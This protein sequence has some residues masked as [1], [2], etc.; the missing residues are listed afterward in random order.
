MEILKNETIDS[1]VLNNMR[2]NDLVDQELLEKHFPIKSNTATRILSF[3]VDKKYKDLNLGRLYCN[4]KYDKKIYSTLLTEKYISI[5]IKDSYV[6]CLIEM[7]LS[8]DCEVPVLLEYLTNKE[9]IL[10]SIHSDIKCAKY[11][12]LKQCAGGYDNLIEVKYNNVKPKELSFL[13]KLKDEIDLLAEKCYKI[14][15]SNYYE[16]IRRN[17][18][19][20]KHT[21]LALLIQTK[22]RKKVSEL[23][24]F[25]EKEYEVG[26]IFHNKIFVKTQSL[27]KLEIN[28]EIYKV[29]KIKPIYKLLSFDFE[30]LAIEQF[31]DLMGDNLLIDVNNNIYYFDTKTGAFKQNDLSLHNRHIKNMI[32]KLVFGGKDYADKKDLYEKMYSSLPINL[33]ER[34]EKIT[35]MENHR[36]SG[37]GKLLFA[38]GYYDFKTKTFTKG[39]NNKILFFDAISYNFPERPPDDIMNNL[40]EIITK[41]GFTSEYYESGDYLLKALTMAIYGDYTR[42][43]IYFVTGPTG[44]GK[45]MLTEF[46]KFT[47]GDYIDNSFAAE[48]LKEKSSDGGRDYSRSIYWLKDIAN[49]RIV[50]SNECS[51]ADKSYDL[52]L[53]K[54]LSSDA[55]KLKARNNYGK[56]EEIM[57]MSTMFIYDNSKM[58][59]D[60]N[61]MEGFEQRPEFI[62]YQISHVDED[63]IVKDFHRKKD[64][65]IKNRLNTEIYRNALVHLI[66]DT[67]NNMEYEEKRDNGAIKRPSVIAKN[68]MDVIGE[69]EDDVCMNDNLDYVFDK[70][71]QITNDSNDAVPCKKI[72]EKMTKF[73]IDEDLG[74]LTDKKLNAYLTCKLGESKVMR[75]VKGGPTVKC[76]ICVKDK[77]I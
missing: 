24:S 19:N 70:L 2:K 51:K 55:D 49:K 4:I 41:S 18:N 61:N 3:T 42:K 76:K 20:K 31:I 17:N 29:S 56:D 25:V 23:I 48:N 58:K 68:Y 40:K 27:S 28:D 33:K 16:V 37:I 34:S 53:I 64:P 66:I 1:Y 67:Y 59:I 38:N 22:E 73:Y 63:K 14:N 77:S 57:N 32:G 13:N 35:Y 36:K 15:S 30:H 8:V 43:K 21:L 12:F 50:I 71:Y 75:I 74:N 54:K 7:A 39:F 52:N 9:E 44:C 62:N 65:D 47:F 60:K 45:S 10:N 6:K 46:L 5:K 69:S 26:R 72:I 11:L